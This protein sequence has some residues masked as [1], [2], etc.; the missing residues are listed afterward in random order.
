M[1]YISLG[2]VNLNKSGDSTGSAR[3][4]AEYG[5]VFLE[6]GIAKRSFNM[7]FWINAPY[8]YNLSPGQNASLTVKLGNSSGE[9]LYSRNSPPGRWDGRDGS[10]YLFSSSFVVPFNS[11]TPDKL[12]FT[13]SYGTGTGL[14]T[15][16]VTST[17]TLPETITRIKKPTSYEKPG[18]IAPNLNFILT[19]KNFERGILNNPLGARVYFSTSTV[20][21]N[22]PYKEVPFKSGFTEA[23]AQVELSLNPIQAPRGGK[24]NFAVTVYGTGGINYQSDLYQIGGILVNSSIPPVPILNL[25]KRQSSTE[26]VHNTT[27]SN[28]SLEWRY[29]TTNNPNSSTKINSST[30]EVNVTR[31]IKKS[32]YYWNFDGLEYS[33]SV[34]L[35]Y[36]SQ[37]DSVIE[38]AN[39]TYEFLTQESG[40][41][42]EQAKL[43]YKLNYDTLSYD[44]AP[45]R[46]LKIKIYNT[47]E[48]YEKLLPVPSSGVSTQTTFNLLELIGKYPNSTYNMKLEFSD[49]LETTKVY[50]F[51]PLD[52]RGMITPELGEITNLATNE[53]IG[54]KRY[55]DYEIE[56]PFTESSDLLFDS[57]NSIII[58][59]DEQPLLYESDYTSTLS[60]FKLRIKI[61]NGKIQADDKVSFKIQLKN[62]AGFFS[63]FKEQIFFQRKQIILSLFNLNRSDSVL[64]S[65]HPFDD[66]SGDY[67]GGFNWPF[68]H[69]EFLPTT[70]LSS[71]GINSSSLDWIKIKFGNRAVPIYDL[72]HGSD[73]LNGT[74]KV[75]KYDMVSLNTLDEDFG[76]NEINGSYN[77]PISL[78]ITD[79][80]G[81]KS[82]VNRTA[83]ETGENFNLGLELNKKISPLF[84]IPPTAPQESIV[85]RETKQYTTETTM[86]YWTN[87]TGKI[88][89][90]EESSGKPFLLKT[91]NNIH[92][93]NTTFE[94]QFFDL[95]TFLG[96]AGANVLPPY[97]EI[98]TLGNRKIYFKFIGDL[99]G[100]QLSN[101]VDC[102]V[103]RHTVPSL[104]LISASGN[105][106]KK[107][108]I[109]YKILDSGG[110]YVELS[111][112]GF[113]HDLK[114]DSEVE[115]TPV[116]IQTEE[117]SQELKVFTGTEIFLQDN[118]L[119]FLEMTSRLVADGITTTKVFRTSSFNYRR[120]VPTLSQ[121]PNRIGFNTNQIG[122]NEIFKIQNAQAAQDT[123]N[124]S[125][126]SEGQVREII[127]N[128]RTGAISGAVIDGSDNAW[129]NTSGGNSGGN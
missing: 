63:S 42:P 104:T 9:V 108:V 126:I 28:K 128:I 101:K 74:F 41:F 21:L 115:I 53:S 119:I 97:R 33:P 67:I 45:T 49:S 123:I 6:G 125:Y 40:S 23:N 13:T 83:G 95:S 32:L 1:S 124:F 113:S 99:T 93:F 70:N 77:F 96:E 26:L 88:E 106:E 37:N 14:G 105:T 3:M 107:P 22:S 60:D 75:N 34:K 62:K 92:L 129:N 86:E 114:M 20:T 2:Y 94:K 57:I 17:F 43:L 68:T 25:P 118:I 103:I 65:H 38:Q 66:K 27:I 109:R 117:V 36:Y 54:D 59:N 76:I 71:F 100:E 52:W 82:E 102:S 18:R 120:V 50:N 80:F 35:E 56:L 91:V 122:A 31:G 39:C 58:V 111:H 30:F 98:D 4:Y 69:E 112:T 116:A 47:E 84:S 24:I 11:N 90:Y 10:F 12:W 48:E 73:E 110:Q 85:L 121:Q 79:V 7:K 89:F 5:P 29:N 46:E 15:F 87:E 72:S 44:I 19:L 51:T 64:A 127:V 81:K 16:S 78:I 55:F 61:L 8:S